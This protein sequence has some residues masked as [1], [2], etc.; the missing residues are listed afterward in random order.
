VQGCHEA[1]P[2]RQS[3]TQVVR[4]RAILAHG[5]P[6]W[7]E[8]HPVCADATYAPRLGAWDS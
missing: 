1:V 6:K 2:S 5:R 4:E 3:D 8:I 7:R